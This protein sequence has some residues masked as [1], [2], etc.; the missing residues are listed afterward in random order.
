[1]ACTVLEED[2]SRAHI[3]IPPKGY[4]DMT[5]KHILSRYRHL[6]GIQS[7][8]MDTQTFGDIEAVENKADFKNTS[9]LEGEKIKKALKNMM[10]LL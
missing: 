6:P 9:I 5:L 1:L 4:N 2:R 7:V 3:R 10:L 8:R